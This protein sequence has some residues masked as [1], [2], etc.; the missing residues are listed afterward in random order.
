MRKEYVSDLVNRLASIERTL[1][2]HDDLLTGHLS[3]C[4]SHDT[5]PS[6]PASA[7][8]AMPTRPD[9]SRSNLDLHA[10][11]LEEPR[12]EES[13]TDGLAMIFVEESTSTYFGE[14]SN[15]HFIRMLLRAIAAVRK[16]PLSVQTVVENEYTLVEKNLAT[17]SQESPWSSENFVAESHA[18]LKI[19]P[20]TKEMDSMLDVFFRSTGLLFPFIHEATMRETYSQCVA[21]GFTRVR[22]TW[23]GTLNMIFAMATIQTGTTSA[24]KSLERSSRFYQR[25]MG[26]CGEVSKHVISLEVVH[27]LLLVVLYCQG[28]QRSVQAWNLHGMLV[29]S[30]MA[31]GLHADR[32]HDPS[33]GHRQESGRRTWLT[34]YC[35]DKVLSMTFGRP[36]AIPEEYMVPKLPAPWPSP[37]TP[38]TSISNSDDLSREFLGV[39][40]GLYEIMGHSLVKQYGAN[41]GRSDLELDEMSRFQASGELRRLLKK[42][43]MNL[44][45][46]LQPCLPGGPEVT[47][48]SQANKLRVILTLKYHNVNILIHRPLLSTALRYMFGSVTPVT[49]QPPYQ[50]QL[51][52]AEAQECVTAAELS[53]DIV[54]SILVVDQ[55][56]DNNLGV[57]FFTLYY[58]ICPE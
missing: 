3:A 25:A 15:I 18:S 49:P 54:Y 44:P 38:I 30:A 36:A 37:T 40:V 22:R 41:V 24:K 2:R 57:W 12:N 34:I 53:I 20:S 7:S 35:L 4:G 28:T 5:T 10:S 46:H 32:T 27:Y 51:A 58:G 26:L 6:I 16:S 39:E 50:V 19:L 13:R 31:L 23:L 52:M 8:H 48:Q 47:E 33:D 45:S 56:A 17:F 14:S 9:S 55:T 43:V 11:A 42:W 29:R 21:S 1:Q